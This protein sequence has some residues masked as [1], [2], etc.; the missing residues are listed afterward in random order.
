MISN[1]F[2]GISWHAFLINDL[3]QGQVTLVMLLTPREPDRFTQSIVSVTP[4]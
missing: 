3:S 1:L 2:L 4:A